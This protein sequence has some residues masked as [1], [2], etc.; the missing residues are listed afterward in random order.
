MLEKFK[1]ICN[2]KI[3]TFKHEIDGLC[4][5]FKCYSM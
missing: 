5:Y 4:T 2:Y 3:Y 1:E